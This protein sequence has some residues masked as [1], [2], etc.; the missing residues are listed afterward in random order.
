V[1][2]GGGGFR[3]GPD[4]RFSALMHTIAR[5]R[6]EGLGKSD[7]LEIAGMRALQQQL[8]H[9]LRHDCIRQVGCKRLMEF[10]VL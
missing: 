4:V 6:E 9:P 10:G 5:G 1:C 8:Q 2:V 3:R 7:K